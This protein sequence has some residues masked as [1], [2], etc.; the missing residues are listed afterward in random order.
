MNE[1]IKFLNDFLKENEYKYWRVKQYL[2]ALNPRCDLKSRRFY[3]WN[4]FVLKFFSKREYIVWIKKYLFFL[5]LLKYSD[6]LFIKYSEYNNYFCIVENK[7]EHIRYPLNKEKILDCMID[8]N[9]KRFKISDL[10]KQGFLYLLDRSNSELAWIVQ[11]KNIDN[12]DDVLNIELDIMK[13][14]TDLYN[15]E[16]IELFEEK[17]TNLKEKFKQ[18]KYLYLASWDI[19]ASNFKKDKFWEKF[20]YI[21]IDEVWYF[22]YYYDIVG[23]MRF[24][25]EEN[26]ELIFS[27]YSQVFWEVDDNILDFFSFY[28]KLH[29]SE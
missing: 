28:R 14:K 25:W 20:I 1:L 9:S 22:N 29:H 21:D 24:L 13:Q 10:H 2:L 11:N 16:N 12:L 8:F 27:R 17:I 4:K 23:L 6:D 3:I 19:H 7:L 26:K 18:E 5:K 15:K